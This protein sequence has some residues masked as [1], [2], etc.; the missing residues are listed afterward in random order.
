[1]AEMTIIMTGE[2]VFTMKDWDDITNELRKFWTR[3]LI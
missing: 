1:V 3:D 2:G